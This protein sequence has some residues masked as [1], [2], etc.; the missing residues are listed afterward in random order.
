MDTESEPGS[1][2]AAPAESAADDVDLPNSAGP[3]G[4]PADPLAA[5]PSTAESGAQIPAADLHLAADGSPAHLDTVR[6]SSGGADVPESLSR[7]AATTPQRSAPTDDGSWQEV[8]AAPHPLPPDVGAWGAIPSQQA[9]AP[10]P[11][12][13][14]IRPPRPGSAVPEGPIPSPGTTGAVEPPMDGTGGLAALSRPYQAV[15]G[16]A[17]ALIA[18]LA[19]T[20]VA[21]VFLHVAPS[22]TVIKEYGKAV[23]AWIYPE[24]E[25]NWKLFAPNPLQQNVSVQ[26]KAEVRRAD[27]GRIVTEW[28]D[29]TA[30]D[31][32][33]IRGNLLPSHVQQNKLRRAWD[34][35]SNSHDDQNRPNG[36]RGRL[37]ESY[38]KRIALVRLEA[39]DLRGVVERVRFRATTVLVEAPKWSDEQTDTRPSHRELPWWTISA[40]DRPGDDGEKSVERT[41][42]VR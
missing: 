1:P 18:L 14:A 38:L 12:L 6:T 21:M 40:D 13:E 2:A 9:Q 16:A 24:F 41:E 17:L 35:Y 42:A 8:P 26:V 7:S 30:E 5:D 31:S 11:S 29:L 25:Q 20:H 27:G 4:V 23:D 10:V 3:G 32:A 39:H 19:S 33:S 15:L 36:L 22:N 28:I 34:L 37:S